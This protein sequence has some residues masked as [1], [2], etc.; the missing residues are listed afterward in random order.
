V[1]VLKVD[2]VGRYR[3][4]RVDLGGRT[5]N[6]IAGEEARI[7]GD[8]TRILLDPANIHIYADSRRVE[9]EPAGAGGA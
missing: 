6:A 5:F 2:D 7:D 4:V 9:G 1:R 8:Q 3:I